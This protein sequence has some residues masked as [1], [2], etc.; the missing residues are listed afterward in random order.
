MADGDTAATSTTLAS[1]D[2]IVVNDAGTMKQVALSDLLTYLNNFL[3]NANAATSVWTI[4]G[5]HRS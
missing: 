5:D 1:T 2:A 4:A 3:V